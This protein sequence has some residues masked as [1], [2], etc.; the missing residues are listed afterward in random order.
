MQWGLTSI[1]DH[2]AE[3][4]DD[5]CALP[6]LRKAKYLH[7]NCSGG[8]GL[9]VYQLTHSLRRGAAEC[10]FTTAGTPCNW[11]IFDYNSFPLNEEHL[12][13]G[14]L[15]GFYGAADVTAKHPH[16]LGGG[17]EAFMGAHAASCSIEMPW[18]LGVRP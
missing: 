2:G 4:D 3:A 11:D 9:A 14:I 6:R 16:L 10:G 17:T 8:L 7:L 18:T 5:S 1:E 12:V 13:G 15:I